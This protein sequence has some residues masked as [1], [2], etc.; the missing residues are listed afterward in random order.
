MKQ[1]CKWNWLAMIY[2]QKW[3]QCNEMIVTNETS[4][5]WNAYIQ[6][7]TNKI[8]DRETANEMGSA[9]KCTQKWN[10]CLQWNDC[11]KWHKQ[12]MKCTL[13]IKYFEEWNPNEIQMKW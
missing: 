2:I 10:K 7:N 11:Y 3:N 12:E 9:M 5:K 6:W 13:S 4:Q 8:N 1:I